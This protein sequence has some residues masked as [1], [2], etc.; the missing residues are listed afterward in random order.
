[1]KTE[2]RKVGEA[3]CA[4]VPW[5][6]RKKQK[7]GDARGRPSGRSSF[8]GDPGATFFC[9]KRETGTKPQETGQ[10]ART[11]SSASGQAVPAQRQSLAEEENSVRAFDSCFSSLAERVAAARSGQGRA[12]F[13]RGESA[14]LTARTA[15][16][17]SAREEK[18]GSQECK[19]A[20]SV[21]P[22]RQQY[23]QECE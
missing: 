18:T 10:K 9:R 12:V 5:E 17:A 1:M 21:S 20:R 6:V 13:G 19:N 22:R 4:P 8:L 2:D 14:P 7:T 16:K 15:A 11:D 3:G 23:E